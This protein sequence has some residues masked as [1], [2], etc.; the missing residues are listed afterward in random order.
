MSTRTYTERIFVVNPNAEQL[1]DSSP[2][3]SPSGSSPSNTN[4]RLKMTKQNSLKAL[5]VLGPEL[6]KENIEIR[7]DKE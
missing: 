7:T 4:Q 2:E 3:P 6:A 1:V 5:R